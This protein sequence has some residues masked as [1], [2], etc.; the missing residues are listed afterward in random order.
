M[1][2]VVSVLLSAVSHLEVFKLL[3]DVG[4]SPG[5]ENPPGNGPINHA[6]VNRKEDVVK[7]LVKKN[8]KT[9]TNHQDYAR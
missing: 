6:V 1:T 4:T 8:L 5:A 2:Q 3:L 7:M 9:N